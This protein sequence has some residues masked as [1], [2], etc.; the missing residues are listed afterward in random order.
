MATFVGLAVAD[1]MFPETLIAIWHP[2]S[3][4]R[5]SAFCQTGARG[6]S[7]RSLG[8]FP[9][10]LGGRGSVVRGGGGEG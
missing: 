4:P 10:P 7:H 5:E 2:R 9:S 3:H 6:L 8:P 1:G